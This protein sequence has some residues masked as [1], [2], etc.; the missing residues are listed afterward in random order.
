MLACWHRASTHLEAVHRQ[1]AGDDA[2]LQ[3]R[4]QHNGVILLIHGRSSACLRVGRAGAGQ[5]GGSGAGGGESPSSAP[6]AATQ[7]WR[8]GSRGGGQCGQGGRQGREGGVGGARGALGSLGGRGSPDHLVNRLPEPDAV[9]PGAAE[10]GRQLPGRSAR[11]GCACDL[12][13]AWATAGLPDQAAAA[14][15]AGPPTPAWGSAS[16]NEG[17]VTPLPPPRACQQSGLAQLVWCASLPVHQGPPAAEPWPHKAQTWPPPL[18]RPA[19]T[20]LPAHGSS[21]QHARPGG[22]RPPGPPL[23]R[24]RRSVLRRASTP[25]GAPAAAAAPAS[26]PHHSPDRCS[27]RPPQRG[28]PVSGVG[29][30]A[31]PRAAAA[32]G[33]AGRRHCSAA[34]VCHRAAGARQPVC[35]T[36]HRQGSQEAHVSSWFGGCAGRTTL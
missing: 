31:G 18:R 15:L 9:R 27:W 11:A 7:S 24:R 12:C 19:R 4:A 34:L 17:Q 1:Q 25:P 23:R 32:G 5:V 26:G 22:S 21:S 20:T 33:P 2:L 8:A 36:A 10:R 28:R 13:C 29:G 30:G 16:A 14:V 35:S 6:S 3:A